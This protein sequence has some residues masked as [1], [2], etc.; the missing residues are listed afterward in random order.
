MIITGIP[1]ITG[2]PDPSLDRTVELGVATARDE[3]VALLGD[4]DID[5]KE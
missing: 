5:V 4:L 3:L 2:T 1:V